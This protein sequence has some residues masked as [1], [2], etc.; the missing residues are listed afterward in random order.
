MQ[1]KILIVDS[2]A[3]NR[4]MLKVKLASA[5]YD[6]AMAA[7]AQ[8]AIQMAQALQP[9]A[10][11]LA[12]CLPDDAALAFCRSLK[13]DETLRRIP[14]VMLVD[15]AAQD[16]RIAALTAGADDVL[17]KPLD[18]TLLL[19]RIRSLLRA[20][21]SADELSLREGTSRALGFAEPA[22]DFE[23][24][25]QV[26]LL[27]TNPQASTR[28]AARLKPYIRDQLR[29]FTIQDALSTLNA[30][31]L[32]D[33][34]VIVLD[35]VNPELGLRLLAEIRARAVTRHVG[36]IALSDPKDSRTAAAALDIGAN[37][38]MPFDG[39]P[40]ELGL[41]IKAQR[42][43][44]RVADRLRDTMRDGLQAAVIDPLSGLYNRRYAIS[45]LKRVAEQ[46]AQSG[47]PFA[48]M[49]A[50]IDHFK[51]VN[52][53]HGHAAGDAVLIEVANRLR[54]NL[55]AVDLVARIGGEE[56]LIVMPNTG[57]ESALAAAKRLC[58][59]I[60]QTPCPIAKTV[61]IA[62][63]PAPAPVL[64]VTVSIGIAIGADPAV[65]D[66]ESMAATDQ[67]VGHLLDRADQALYGAKNRGRNCVRLSRPA[68]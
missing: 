5:Y 41:R 65:T 30:Q 53:R 16:H 37:D 9:D 19:A 26:A 55:R 35:R 28:L 48:V 39:D 42:H 52:D 47:K 29:H 51:L 3:T 68:A 22:S 63:A 24:I 21:S 27:G 17:S 13:S 62:T 43:Q 4:I 56:F 58:R 11:L 31:T 44:K 15:A 61:N 45:H 10:I 32:P 2:A 49:I 18:D 33:V 8:E 34:I 36:I 46:A 6:V 66:P 60:E 23:T 38:V 25:G 7:S 57:L 59:K 64:S 20:R 14:V 67:G 1:G 12:M 40:A 54:Q 50:D